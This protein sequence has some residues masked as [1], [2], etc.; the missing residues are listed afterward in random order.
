MAIQKYRSSLSDEMSPSSSFSSMLDRFFN[1]S[2]NSRSM[3]S[4]FTPHVD[5]CETDKGYEIEVSL[6]GL[7]KDEINIDFQ[8]G[9]LT[10]SGERRFSDEKKDKKYHMIE[11]QYGSFS[12][13]FYLPD[14]VNP[15]GID[16]DFED[17]VLKITVPK[18]TRK[19][20]KH[21]I[22]IKGSSSQDKNQDMGQNKDQD[23]N[24]KGNKG[25][26]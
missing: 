15:E 3:M 22:K 9:R 20:M 25:N 14:T 24:I 18:D 13:S 7:K 17:G 4:N 12:R 16:A 11:S 5:T 1:D 26:K 2:L 8:E 23:K 21:Q 19:T 6:P 10:I